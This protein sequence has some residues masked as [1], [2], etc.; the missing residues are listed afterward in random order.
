MDT[1][2]I[3]V[4]NEKLAEFMLDNQH[5]PP[6]DSDRKAKAI[7]VGGPVIEITKA[8]EKITG[9]TEGHEHWMTPVFNELDRDVTREKWEERRQKMVQEDVKR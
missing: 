8:L 7:T 3:H 6:R 5:R 4:K 9:D 2:K 1:L